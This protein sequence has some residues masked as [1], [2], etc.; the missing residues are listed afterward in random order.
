MICGDLGVAEHQRRD[1]RVVGGEQPRDASTAVV[2]DDA[3]ALEA[4]GVDEAAQRLGV[5]LQADRRVVA[6]ARGADARQIDEVAGK[7]VARR[8]ASS[9]KVAMC[10]G[11]P[12]TNNTFG[13]RPSTRYAI[14]L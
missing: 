13:P 9:R 2:R 3:K 10:S 6:A 1:A 5:T 7:R 11:Q 4:D 14:W 8:G 12:C